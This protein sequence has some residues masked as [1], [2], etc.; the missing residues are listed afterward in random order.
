ML[1]VAGGETGSWKGWELSLGSL[2]FLLLL[3][4]LHVGKTVLFVIEHGALS[5]I[6]SWGSRL[7]CEFLINITFCLRESADFWA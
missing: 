6:P 5:F 2:Y 7:L 4:R 3:S 1:H